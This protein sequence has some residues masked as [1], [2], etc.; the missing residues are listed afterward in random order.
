MTLNGNFTCSTLENVACDPFDTNPSVDCEVVCNNRRSLS[1]LPRQLQSVNFQIII[2]QIC[3]DPGINCNDLNQAQQIAGDIYD[4]AADA[5]NNGSLPN[6]ELRVFCFVLLL[7]T[8]FIADL[9]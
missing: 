4:L 8:N 2:T 7:R 3:N 6:G 9:F 5:I 1:L